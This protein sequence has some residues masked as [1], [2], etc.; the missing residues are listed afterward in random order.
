MS[1][2]QGRPRGG[3]NG[4]SAARGATRARVRAP[5][6]AVPAQYTASEHIG[7]RILLRLEHEI[8]LCLANAESVR[9]AVKAVI[10]AVCGTLSWDC[11]RLLRVDE[12][13]GVLRYFE[14]WSVEGAD[15]ARFIERSREVA[16]APGKGLSGHVWQ[17]GEPVW[18]TD[19]TKDPRVQ[20]GLAIGTVMRGAFH[21][22][23]TA[24]GKVIGVLA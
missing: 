8:A 18:V 2:P 17:S 11:G 15:I 19:L 3:K 5:A 14:H 24:Q 9:T 7:S 20:F 12:A 1:S 10:R 21:F 23:V 22:P 4:E 13:A 6:P 16:H